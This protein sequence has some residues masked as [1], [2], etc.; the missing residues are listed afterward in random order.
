MFRTRSV[1]ALS[2]I[3]VV[4]AIVGLSAACSSPAA[5][6]P[7]PAPRATRTTAAPVPTTPTRPAYC[8]PLAELAARTNPEFAV[9]GVRTTEQEQARYV[10]LLKQV[11]KAASADGRKDVAALFTTLAASLLSP[12]PTDAQINQ[13]AALSESALS[14][15]DADCG[16]TEM[17]WGE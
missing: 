14:T 2:T 5:R 9:G 17:P 11:A 16:M 13:V 7:V 3:A 1:K 15:E 10:A 8:A 6:V 4:S 12:P